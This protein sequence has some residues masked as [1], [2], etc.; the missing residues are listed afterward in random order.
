MLSIA[1]AIE[2]KL[3]TNTDKRLST[4]NLVCLAT[5]NFSTL[6]LFEFYA[7]RYEMDVR[8]FL[9]RRISDMYITRNANEKLRKH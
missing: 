6:Q 8:Y 9:E 4:E 3:K 1:Q 2:E 7:E 5:D